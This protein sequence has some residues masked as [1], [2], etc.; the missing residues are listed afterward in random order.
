MGSCNWTVCCLQPACPSG[1][2][3]NGSVGIYPTPPHPH[4]PPTPF[5]LS[6]KRNWVSG[7]LP[8][9][10]KPSL[11]SHP[12]PS[13]G[14]EKVGQWEVHYTPTHSLTSHPL[15]SIGQEKV[16]QWEVPYTPSPLPHT[17][18]HLQPPSLY[19]AVFTFVQ[20]ISSSKRSA[21]G[22]KS[23]IN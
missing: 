19:P 3:E 9:T 18:I 20:N 11:T 1:P 13:I 10:P 8:Y 23:S 15:P 14:Q 16:G 7:S 6:A 5:P 22:K 4:S 17:P 2:I 21:R 12:L